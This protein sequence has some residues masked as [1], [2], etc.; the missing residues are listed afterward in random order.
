MSG[1]TPGTRDR[2]SRAQ[3]QLQPREGCQPLCALDLGHPNPLMTP[4]VK[5]PQKAPT[6]RQGDEE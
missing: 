1:P 4:G 3:C 5:Y 6:I 2:K